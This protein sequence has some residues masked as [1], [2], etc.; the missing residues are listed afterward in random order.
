MDQKGSKTDLH[1][2][3]KQGFRSILFCQFLRQTSTFSSKG[4]KLLILTPKGVAWSPSYWPKSNL[5]KLHFFLAEKSRAVDKIK[6]KGDKLNQ[7]LR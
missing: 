7:Q 5:G 3:P 1:V 2:L 4:A 6:I